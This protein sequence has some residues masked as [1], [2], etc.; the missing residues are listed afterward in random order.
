MAEELI[1]ALDAGSAWV[2]VLVASLDQEH[3]LTLLAQAREPAQG[4]RNGVVVNIEA[5]AAAMSRALD[6]AEQL[7]GREI[8]A[9]CVGVGGRHLEARNTQGAITITPGGREITPADRARAIEAAREQ[10]PLGENRALLHQ[11]PRGYVVDDQDGVHNPLGMAGYKLEVET[12]LITASATMLQNL[13][14]SVARARVDLAG[15]VCA[16]LAAARAVLTSS[17]REMGAMVVDLGAGTTGVALYAQGFPWH[18]AE[19]P[20]GGAAITQELAV[21]LRLPPEVAE[22]LKISYGHCDPREFADDELIELSDESLVLPRSELAG[23]VESAAGDL[24][25]Q[26]RA[27]LREAQRAGLGPMGVVLTG[28]GAELAG[29]V[30]LAQRVLGLP[31]RVGSPYG[32]RGLR[33]ETGGP[34]CATAAG[35]LLWDARRVHE[36]QAA[37]GRRRV[38]GARLEWMRTRVERLARAFLP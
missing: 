16:P 12:H 33:E 14:K 11:L 24:L 31:A 38:G 17:E 4:M 23:I 27:P 28:G 2:T 18:T 8:T 29:I 10:A 37:R 3:G 25:A 13:A 34:A 35:L 26:L 21:G 32:V 5:A 1:V 19:L 7:S 30:E 36:G 15:A 22:P 9:A 20:V 6:R